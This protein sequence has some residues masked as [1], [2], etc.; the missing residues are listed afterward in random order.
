M[1]HNPD[2]TPERSLR[3]SDPTTRSQSLQALLDELN[4]PLDEGSDTGS[5]R[6]DKGL[7]DRMRDA[8]ESRMLMR[9]ARASAKK[10][11]GVDPDTSVRKQ[12]SIL[13]SAGAVS[14]AAFT[15][16]Q[17][18][19]HTGTA[20]TQLNFAEDVR[21]PALILA[22]SEEFKNALIE[23]EGVRYTVYR[24]I[25]GYPTVGVGHLVQPGDGLRVG[26]RISEAQVLEF[27]E[28]DLRTAER[29]VRQ[30][31]GDLPLHQHEFDALLDLVY[32][33]GIG[34]VSPSESPRLNDAIAQ[35]DYEAIADE[36]HYTTARGKV[37]RGLEFRSERRTQI[38]MNASYDDPRAALGNS[39]V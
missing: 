31:V 30:L 8:H 12:A 6:H 21:Q 29:G 28:N 35:A 26:D 24:D 10:A 15:A 37:A 16:P 22:A 7:R 23:E 1:N 14:L 36:L 25:A 9:R 3:A 20:V 11:L 17:V 33:V 2:Q 38:F 18:E 4:R 27:L 34:N 5:G 32:N 19:K 39:S 13:M